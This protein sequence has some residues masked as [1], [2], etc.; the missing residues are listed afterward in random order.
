MWKKYRSSRKN[1]LDVLSSISDFY[2]STWSCTGRQ[3]YSHQSG[4]LLAQTTYCHRFYH[5]EKPVTVQNLRL[6]FTRAKR[7]HKHF[8]YNM[9]SLELIFFKTV[10]RRLK[11]FNASWQKHIFFFLLWSLDIIEEMCSICN[12]KLSTKWTL[13]RLWN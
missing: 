5:E 4:P 8:M 1:P 10:W 7:K 6:L 3:S 11:S 2:R 13:N 9:S 12:K